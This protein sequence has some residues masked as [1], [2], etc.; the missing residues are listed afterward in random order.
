MSF[1]WYYFFELKPLWKHYAGWDTEEGDFPG[2]T[3][4]AKLETVQEVQTTVCLLTQHRDPEEEEVSL[5]PHAWPQEPQVIK[6]YDQDILFHCI[7]L[8]VEPCA[9]TPH[10]A[11]HGL[12]ASMGHLHRHTTATLIHLSSLQ[13]QVQ[14]RC[15]VTLGM[16]WISSCLHHPSLLMSL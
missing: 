3:E 13:V 10:K 9:K 1:T 16:R 12:E 11:A 5:Q 15:P 4:A 14:R 6:G 8:R 7:I 2:V